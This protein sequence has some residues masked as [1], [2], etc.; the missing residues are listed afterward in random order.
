[1]DT[2]L[3]IRAVV[4]ASAASLAACASVGRNENVD[5]RAMVASADRSE[6]DRQTDQRRNPELLLAFTGVRRGMR[7]LDMGAGGG[8]STELLARAVGSGGTVYAQDSPGVSPRANERFDERAKTPAM[9]NVV[10]VLRD[11]DDPVPPGVRD[12]DLITFF[13]AYHDT[14]FMS[15]DRA[16]M[17]R[18]LFE[19]LKPG[20]VLVIADHSAQAGAGI[21]V[22][23]SLHRIEEA[24]LRREV[25]AAGFRLAAEGDFL[26]H[27][28]DPRDSI[29]FRP[30][31]PVDEFVLRF[32]RP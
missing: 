3:L 17:N 10:R 20:G 14:A 15:V 6:A 25:E 26:R 13:F 23:K 5:Y 4:L 30:K 12:L 21:S 11:Y 22:A 16:K 32:V 29:V 28:E 1:M 19:A 9:R 27:R 18:A 2:E 7:V 24:T 31:V 8:Y